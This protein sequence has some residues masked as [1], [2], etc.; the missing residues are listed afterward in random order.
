MSVLSSQVLE[1]D[2]L[3]ESLREAVASDDTLKQMVFSLERKF[4]R[5]QGAFLPKSGASEVTFRNFVDENRM[6]AL[7]GGDPNV[8][9]MSDSMIERKWEMGKEYDNWL[10]FELQNFQ[11]WF[12]EVDASL[13]SAP[14]GDVIKECFDIL[15]YTEEMIKQRSEVLTMR[16]RL[17]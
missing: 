6:F 7:K 17:Q 13:K 2:S 11:D 9:K 5:L 12:E 1:V 10:E 4:E 16:G 3:S 8:Q 14:I 15:A